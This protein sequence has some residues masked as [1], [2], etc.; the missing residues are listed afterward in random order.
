ML[1]VLTRGSTLGGTEALGWTM[2]LDRP[3]T[4]RG[5]PHPHQAQGYHLHTVGEGMDV[6]ATRETTGDMACHPRLQEQHDD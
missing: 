3:T 1:A 4:D 6:V 5:R 2:V